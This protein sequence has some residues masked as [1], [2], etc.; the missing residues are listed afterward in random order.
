MERADLAEALRPWRPKPAAR[1]VAPR[2]YLAVSDP[3]TFMGRFALAAAGSGEVF[4]GNPAWGKSEQELVAELLGANREQAGRPGWLM[5]PTGGTSGGVRFARHDSQTIAAA[6]KGFSQHFGLRQVNAVGVLP[7]HHVSGLVAWLRCALTSGSY[8][9]G[10]W[11]AIASGHLPKLPEKAEGWML[12]LVPT[13]LERLLQDVRTI[14]WLR[15]FRI[16]FIGGA[17]P[18][19]TLLERAAGAGLPLSPG[20]GMSETAAMVA[21]LRPDEFLLGSRSCGT[22]LPHARLDFNVEGVISITGSSVFHGY[23]PEFSE[24]RTF[25]TEDIG[26]IDASGRLRVFGR[27]DGVIIT[28]GEK[29]HPTEVES[30]LRG[31]GEFPDLLVL[32]VPHPVW[33]QQVAVAYPGGCRPDAARVSRIVTRELAAYKHP[34]LYVPVPGWP[35]AA[36]GKL[37]RAEISRYVLEG[38]KAG[39]RPGA[40]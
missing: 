26:E 40:T 29:V 17:P 37:R 27:R 28:G 22:M 30:V 14:E 10:D 24:D 25:E 2:R 19:S 13:Q 23:Y 32:G 18:W 8:V 34:K 31:T 20:Y 33:G 16:I 6:V 39:R 11:R 5:I 1:P 15:R 9:A 4:L 3:E 7:L 21:A 36:N 12:S 38:M 35:V